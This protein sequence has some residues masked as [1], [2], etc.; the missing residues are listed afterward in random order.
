MQSLWHN[1][2]KISFWFRNCCVC[3]LAVPPVTWLCAGCWQQLRS[4]YLHPED[5]IREQGGLTH[6]RLFDWGEENDF[7]ARLF[8][9]SLKKRKLGFIFESLAKDFLHRFLQV[10]DL[11]PNTL[12]VPA[13]ASHQNK[14]KNHA[15]SICHSLSHVVGMDSQNPLLILNHMDSKQVQKRKNKKERRKINFGVQESFSVE[16][17]PLV[18]VDDILTTGATARSA[19]KALG[20]PKDF[21][22]FTLSWRRF[23]TEDKL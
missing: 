21:M 3:R 19:W 9:N 15:L 6:A 22:I 18:F 23:L 11:P 7:F 8:L 13:P 20:K 12:F 5:M 1:R 14:L 4:F 2:E 10:R 17:R 16:K